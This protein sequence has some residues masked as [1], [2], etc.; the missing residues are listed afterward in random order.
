MS[1]ACSTP[2][3]WGDTLTLR[4]NSEINGRTSYQDGTF[5]VTARFRSG[6]KVITIDRAE[7]QTVEINS[8]DFNSGEPPKDVS[9]FYE[10]RV[11]TRDASAQ[12]SSLSAKRKRQAKLSTGS[13]GATHS[14]LEG[15]DFNPSTD[16]V[17]WLRNS[18]RMTGRLVSINNGEVRLEG[19]KKDSKLQLGDVVKIL[20]APN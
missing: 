4:D 19:V 7:V 20:I 8:R 11:S 12:Q 1:L 5:S 3:G 14:I 18:S 15:S 2:F 17:L 10:K 13:E 16:D 9:I 6:A